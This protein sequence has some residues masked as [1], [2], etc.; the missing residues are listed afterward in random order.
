MSKGRS[1]DGV[2]VEWGARLFYPPNRVV[3][4]RR[5]GGALR[6]ATLAA[7][8]PTPAAVR[9]KISATL[10]Q[11]PQAVVKVTGGGRGMAHIAAHF[12][13]ITRSGQLA[14]E[15]E[16][17]E[18]IE[19][20]EA[21]RELRDDWKLGGTEIA[22]RSHRREAYNIVLSMPRTTDAE[23]VRAAAREF[24]QRE[25]SNHAYVMVLHAPG[26]DAKTDRPHVHLAVRAEGF[27]GRRLNPRKADLQRWREGFA[28][29]LAERGVEA[30]ATRREARGET[31]RPYPLWEAHHE[32]R[33]G[34]R[35][36]TAYELE[37]QRDTLRAWRE[38][39]SALAESSEA[40]DRDTAIEITRFVAQMP[41]AR[42]LA[43]NADRL[44]RAPERELLERKRAIRER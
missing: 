20:K 9:A 22:E 16:R 41:A 13:Y 7:R 25:F 27:D 4:G 12:N 2:L 40:K 39:A 5:G 24:A 32:R 36:V 33:N 30:L 3:K 43:A 29:A 15:N 10:R 8:R 44:H 34:V 37:R 18:T 11:A 1:I 35:E 28:E 26:H 21:L 23:D 31:R 38:I 42:L 6:L 17:G 14:L 19:G